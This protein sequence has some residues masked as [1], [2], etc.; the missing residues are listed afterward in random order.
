MNRPFDEMLI[1]LCQCTAKQNLVCNFFFVK[2]CISNRTVLGAQ[3][4]IELRLIETL[5]NKLVTELDEIKEL[6]L[7]TIHFC[8]MVD[9]EQALADEDI[10]SA[11]NR[12][13]D[14]F[15]P[16]NF[17]NNQTKEN[18]LVEEQINSGQPMLTPFERHLLLEHLN[19]SLLKNKFRKLIDIE[20]R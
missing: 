13:L 17:L 2:E 4:L 15:N 5:F 18:N 10:T 6:I 7:N 8:L 20:N 3:N 11:L 1:K 14:D 9:V 12:F 16:K 19:H